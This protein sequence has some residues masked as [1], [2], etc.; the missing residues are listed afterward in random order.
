MRI[1]P[2]RHREER[3]NHC[4]PAR[5]G[6]LLEGAHDG[7]GMGLAF[8]RHVQRC[9]VIVHVL[10]GTRADPLADFEAINTHRANRRV[11]VM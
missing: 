6:C 4:R 5:R 3:S 2:R 1:S 10:D 9:R 11:T 8:L 7:I